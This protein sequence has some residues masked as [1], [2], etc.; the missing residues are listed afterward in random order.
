MLNGVNATCKWD[1]L[2]VD[3][4]DPAKIDS[5]KAQVQGGPKPTIGAGTECTFAGYENWHISGD[6]DP[7]ACTFKITI[8]QPDDG[9]PFYPAVA[10]FTN[11]VSIAGFTMVSQ[12]G[13][14]GTV[15]TSSTPTSI[16]VSLSKVVLAATTYT[17]QFK[18]TC[19]S[20]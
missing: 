20:P 2:G 1:Q 12:G 15:T 13:F 7:T 19:S 5:R 6:V 17:L 16:S 10:A 3:W 11:L 18:I 4:W 8:Q 9:T 14:P